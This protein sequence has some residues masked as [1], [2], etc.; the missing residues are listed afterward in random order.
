M[1]LDAESERDALA[2]DSMADSPFSPMVSRAFPTAVDDTDTLERMNDV[3]EGS[4]IDDIPEASCRVIQT[5][6]ESIRGRLLGD[7]KAKGVAI[8]GFASKDDL[9]IA[10]EDNRNI[11]QRAWDAIV[12]FFKGIYDRFAG[13]FKKKKTDAQIFQKRLDKGM[14]TIG[15]MLKIGRASC[16]ERVSSPV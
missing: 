9:K 8:E 11:I 13:F 4:D 3:L 10:I 14:D 5:A 16:R 6:M 12:K 7:S 15:E 1:A 2:G